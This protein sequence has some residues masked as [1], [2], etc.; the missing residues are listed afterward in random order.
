MNKNYS[1]RVATAL[2][3]ATSLAALTGCGGSKPAAPPVGVPAPVVAP[4]APVANACVPITAQ[5]PF[6][7]TN[8]Y[9]DS[10]S[11]RGGMVPY[12]YQQNSGTVVLGGGAAGPFQRQGVD[13]T[14]AMNITPN[15]PAPVAGAYPGMQPMMGPMTAN[16]SGVLTISAATQQEIQYYYGGYGQQYGGYPGY[17]GGGYPMPGQPIAPQPA[18]VVPQLCASGLS[19]DLGHYQTTL[20]GKVYLYLNNS[21]QIIP[22]QF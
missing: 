7:G 14:I 21:Q 20:F 4:P 6:T 8:V 17:Y 12:S 18:P 15:Q 22:L 19:F 1:K 2:A 9:F 3:L 10:A 11:V 5:I 16:V 13:G